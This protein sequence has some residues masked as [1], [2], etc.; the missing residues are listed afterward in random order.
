MD[1]VKPRW[2]IYYPY[3]LLRA[4]SDPN[5]GPPPP[6]PPSPVGYKKV[7][8]FNMIDLGISV[9]QVLTILTST[10]ACISLL[11]SWGSSIP[12]LCV[13]VDISVDATGLI[14]TRIGT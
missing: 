8:T 14:A 2:D 5:P 6:P 10:E 4:M 3:F 13:P 11:T 7:P 1:I 12:I 9:F